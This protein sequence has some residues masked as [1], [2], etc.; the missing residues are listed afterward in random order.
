[1]KHD[2]G[3][4]SRRRPN[5][6]HRPEP[7]GLRRQRPPERAQTSIAT[8]VRSVLELQS[9][10]LSTNR[11]QVEVDIPGDLPDVDLDA[12]RCSRS[13]EPDD[14]RYSGVPDSRRASAGGTCG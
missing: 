14:Q 13:P 7:A 9:Y 6:A 12:P 1:M 5:Q 8:L 4:W 3:L 2:A 11:L 10:A